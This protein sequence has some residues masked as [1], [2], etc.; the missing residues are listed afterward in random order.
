MAI[1]ASSSVQRARQELA[2][3]LRHIRLDAGL[4]GRALSSAAG[5]HEA[6]TSRVESAK[7]APSYADIRIWCQ[8]CQVPDQA[9][10]L[11]AA[12][13]A[14]VSMY[15]EWRRLNRT[16]LRRLQET[17]RDVVRAHEAVRLA[18]P[19]AWRAH[20]RHVSQFG[21]CRAGCRPPAPRVC[22]AGAGAL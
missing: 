13:R 20:G 8:A 2:D 16:G 11:I 10:D 14:A 21:F 18:E 15:Q 5:W 6:K 17:R 1:S 19:A 7:Q 4:T 9:V 22:T 3:R 12:S